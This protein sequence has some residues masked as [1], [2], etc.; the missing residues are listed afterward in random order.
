MKDVKMCFQ[1]DKILSFCVA[2]QEAHVNQCYKHFY[3]FVTELSLVERKELEPLVSRLLQAVRIC[4][5]TP[6]WPVAGPDLELKGAPSF[7][8]LALPA[9]LL[10]V[11]S[12]FFF[13]PR[14]G[15]GGGVGAVP[16]LDPPLVAYNCRT[17]FTES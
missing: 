4:L 8:L 13:Y 9:F 12:S 7:V 6:W 16:P 1:F 3:Y 2:F 5:C 14:R 10:S 17:P 11:I 15:G